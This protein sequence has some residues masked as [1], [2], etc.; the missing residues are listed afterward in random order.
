MPEAKLEDAR[1]PVLP[2]VIGAAAGMLAVL[3]LLA[4]VHGLY[5]LWINA[6]PG[7]VRPAPLAAASA[8]RLDTYLF[9]EVAPPAKPD[10]RSQAA[11]GY[12]W[13]DPAHTRVSIP[14]D[15]AMAMVA[16]RGAAGLD[17]VPTRPAP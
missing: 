9:R 15:R 11:R 2:L 7:P 1:F 3:A 12:R 8:P 16:A 6:R 10:P 4:L 14:I 5:S 13:R 17:P